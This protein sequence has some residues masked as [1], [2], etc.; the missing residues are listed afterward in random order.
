MDIFEYHSKRKLAVEEVF[1]TTSVDSTNLRGTF[2]RLKNVMIAELHA[3]W[4]IV[5]LEKYAQEKMTPRSLRWNISPDQGDNDLLDWFQF[6]NG[7]GISLLNFLIDRKRKKV[8]RLN[9]EILEIKERLTPHM[10]EE[11]YKMYNQELRELITIEEE[12]QKTKKRNKYLRDLEDYKTSRVFKW[13]LHMTPQND[14]NTENLNSQEVVEASGVGTEGGKKEPVNKN[15]T[16]GETGKG[17]FRHPKPQPSTRPKNKPQ[18]GTPQRHPGQYNNTNTKNKPRRVSYR[19]DSRSPQ[20]ETVRSSHHE[21]E[22]SRD[23]RYRRSRSRSPRRPYMDYMGNYPEPRMDYHPS[24]Y[25][26]YEPLYWEDRGERG[27]RERS[28]HEY[29]S[30]L[31]T[32]S[33]SFLGQGQPKGK[34]KKQ[35]DVEEEGKGKRKK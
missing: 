18:K 15:S 25:N 8:F 21:R 22:F 23:R 16:G 14:S 29:R 1:D 20:R 7:A 31:S 24:T 10:Q 32:K 34:R 26:R 17:E 13:Q 6:F 35:E 28:P 5:F 19:R 33:K 30:P 4:D 9:K 27:G 3:S 12:E 2:M 11:S